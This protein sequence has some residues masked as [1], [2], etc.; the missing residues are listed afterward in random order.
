MFSQ[1]ILIED[2]D[3]LYTKLCYGTNSEF[4]VNIWNPYKVYEKNCGCLTLEELFNLDTVYIS[5]KRCAGGFYNKSDTQKFMNNIMYNSKKLCEKVLNGTFIPKYYKERIICE[6]GKYRVIKPPTFEC[7]VVQKVLC[8]YMIRPLLEP[9]MTHTCY[10]SVKGRGTSK[11]YE[12]INIGLNNALNKYKNF[13]VIT[14]DCKNYFGSIPIEKLMNKLSK[15]IKDKRVLDLI[16]SF[17][18]DEYGLSLGNEMS[19][20][21][22]S[23][24]PSGVDHYLKDCLKLDQYRYMDDQLVIVSDEIK[25]EVIEEYQARMNAL[26][27]NCPN[28]KIHIYEK[29][30][31][32]V[33]C[34]E[35]YHWNKQMKRYQHFINP[36]IVGKEEHKIYV[37][38]D[39][40]FSGEMSIEEILLQTNGVIGSVKSHPNTKK[41]VNKLLKL[42]NEA[43]RLNT[44]QLQ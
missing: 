40:M 1:Q 37:F 14:F 33:F 6:R 9:K 13:D 31:D 2:I 8:D 15:Y 42:Q 26:G 39:K 44:E 43:I 16:R 19:Q 18:P 41:D 12:D 28:D 27:L 38:I 36:K 30:H 23:W 17:S 11:M 32:F 21:P 24:Y 34:K 29:C 22:A 3:S 7:K 10:A 20:I 4:P 25:D 35:R 5:A